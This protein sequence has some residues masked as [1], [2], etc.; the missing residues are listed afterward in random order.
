M[1]KRA[2]DLVASGLCS[3]PAVAAARWPPWPIKLNDRG[4]V[5]F[6]QVRVGRNGGSSA[7]SSSARWSSTPR[8]VLAQLQAQN[9]R[10]GPLFKMD[11]RPPRRPGLGRFLRDSQPRRAAP[12]VQRAARRDEPGRPA[13]GAARRGRRSSTRRCCERTQRAAR[14]S[15]ACGRSRPATTR[16]STPTAAS[17][18]STSR[19]GRSPSTSS[20]CWPPSSR[21]SPGP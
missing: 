11:R 2:I 9:E 4:P 16:R 17:T 18:S 8:R 12:A 21:S 13:A 3:W 6:R 20:S 1:A 5:L 15:P 7:S 19:T 14:A 10:K